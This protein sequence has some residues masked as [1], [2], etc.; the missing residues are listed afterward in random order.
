MRSGAWTEEGDAG[1]TRR[2]APSTGA[3]TGRWAWRSTRREVGPGRVPPLRVFVWAPGW[4]VALPHVVGPWHCFV[5]ALGNR[6]IETNSNACSDPK[7]KLM[8]E[9]LFFNT[10]SK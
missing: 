8:R 9:K 1:L 7:S 4:E 3:R 2:S 6:N 5:C 10:R